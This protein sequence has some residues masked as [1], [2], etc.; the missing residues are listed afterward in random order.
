MG[1]REITQTQDKID[2]ALAL[3]P[4]RPLLTPEKAAEAWREFVNLKQKLLDDEDYALIIGKKLIRKSGFRKL[5]VVFNLSDRIIESVRTD[6]EDESFTWRI[7][8]EVQAPNGRT[9]TGVA[10]C[11]SRERKFAHAEHDVYSTCHT[12]AKNRAISDMVA[13]GVVSAEEM[14]STPQEETSRPDSTSI[15]DTVILKKKWNWNKVF[16]EFGPEIEKRHKELGEK[17]FTFEFA[18]VVVA[19]EKGLVEGLPK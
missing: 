1:D 15:F 17:K 10:V 19:R 3:A 8:V 16:E 4:V 5:G 9:C 6:R 2:N 18:T 12:R 7:V 14:T 11:D 13:G